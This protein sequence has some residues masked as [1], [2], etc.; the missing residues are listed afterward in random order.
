MKPL[1]RWSRNSWRSYN[2][3]QSCLIWLVWRGGH[4]AN[5]AVLTGLTFQP[6]WSDQSIQCAQNSNL[7]S[8]LNISH[9]GDRNA[10]LDVQFGVWMR[11]LWSWREQA[12]CQTGLTGAN[13]GLTGSYNL[14][15]VRS[16]ILTCDLYRFRLLLGKDLPTQYLW[17]VTADW[18]K[19]NLINLLHLLFCLPNLSSNL[20]AAPLLISMVVDDILRLVS[21]RRA[22]W[23][24]P[25]PDGVPPGWELWWPLLVCS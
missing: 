13:D 7:T 19:Y 9:R 2:H 18:G 12:L 16:C 6:H 24:R 3:S 22:R 20:H 14:I 4:L 25:H 11:E 5:S 1:P 23:R 15:W 8:P 10:Y 17:R 21:R